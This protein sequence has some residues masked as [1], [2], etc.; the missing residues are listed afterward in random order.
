M[1]RI[2]HTFFLARTLKC[3]HRYYTWSPHCIDI[4]NNL[5]CVP[6]LWG[7]QQETDFN[8][9]IQATIDSH[10]VQAILSM[11]E[12]NEQGQSNLGPED[13]ANMWKQYLEPLRSSKNVRLGSPAPSSNPNGLTWMQS[14][15]DACNGGCSVDFIALRESIPSSQLKEYIR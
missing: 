1:V 9:S 10:N 13:A 8:S 5:E 7:P 3:G 14:F 15:S 12:P 4:A 11:N 2:F 6:M